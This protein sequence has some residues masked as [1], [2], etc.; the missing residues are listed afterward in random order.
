MKLESLRCAVYARRSTE[1]HQA[2]SI[3]VQTEEARRYCVQQGGTLRSEHVYSDSGVSRAEF[4]KRP[5]LLRLLNAADAKAFDVVIVRDES[6]L[7]GDTFRAGIIIQDLVESGIRLFYYYSDEEVL[8]ERAVDKFMIAARNFG[9]ELEREKIMQRTHEHLLTKARRGLNVGGRVYGYDNNEVK[10]GER[11]V[12]VEYAI[13][14]AQAKI[15][16]EIFQRYAD[17][18]GL[19]TLAKDLNAR[20][21]EPPKAG[22]RGTGSWSY[23]SIREMVRRERYRGMLIWGRRAKAYRCGT[24][25]RL[26][27]PKADWITVEAPE[28]RIIEDSL[29][30]AVQDRNG[31][32]ERLSGTS[33]RGPAP[34][35]FLSGLGRCTTCGGPIKVANAKVSYANVRVYGCGWHRDRGAAAC[36]NGLRRPVDAV[37][38][39]VAAWL[40]EKV[41]TERV[42]SL[43]LE[44]L[45]RRAHEQARTAEGQIPELDARV[46]QLRAELGRLGAALLGGEEPPHTV[47]RMIAEREEHL[48]DM[49]DR[50]AALRVTPDVLAEQLRDLRVDALERLEDLTGLL[51]RNPEEARRALEVVLGGPLRFTPVETQEGWRYRIE[52]EAIVENL[53]TIEGV[54][55]RSPAAYR[56]PWPVTSRMT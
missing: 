34:R 24:K 46:R 30:A 10:E 38:A 44:E 42:I 27:R 18:E 36:P 13:N 47:M 28:L 17:G 40:R 56:S 49:E 43:A 35:Y 29:W 41:L 53:F 31:A 7:G 8:V 23:S 54:P 20:G 2:A 37:D 6:R 9:A 52:G 22:R 51:Q 19:R 14:E 45:E 5:G 11:R 25:V 16:R 39:A 4:K 33:R 48:A 32:R 12:R 26:A 1:E 55:S 15:V 50:L 3:E 21:V